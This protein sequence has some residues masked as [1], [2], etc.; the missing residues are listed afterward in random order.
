MLLQIGGHVPNT[1]N[2]TTNLIVWHADMAMNSFFA[3]KSSEIS[4]VK[5]PLC[6]TYWCV[7]NR[8]QVKLFLLPKNAQNWM[9]Q[10]IIFLILQCWWFNL[11][12]AW[13]QRA[14][15]WFLPFAGSA[16]WNSGRELLAWFPWSYLE[17]TWYT[18]RCPALWAAGSRW[19]E[20]RR[21]TAN[22]SRRERCSKCN[23]KSAVEYS[24]RLLLI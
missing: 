10:Y 6:S 7:F 11:T 5:R 9:S 4:S 17:A 12:Q 2:L 14:V 18:K 16:C 1:V 23:C 21:A 3:K 20:L 22:V 24:S 8:P 15:C 13:E 19:Q